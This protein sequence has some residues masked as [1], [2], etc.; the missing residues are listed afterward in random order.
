MQVICVTTGT[1]CIGGD[2]LTLTGQS[3]N[4]CHA[5][6]VARRCLI[7]YCYQQLQLLVDEDSTE[8]IFERSPDNDRFRLKPSITFHLYISTSPCGDGRLFAPQEAP[9]EPS[10][11]ATNPDQLS[12]Q[13]GY[14]S[15]V[16]INRRNTI[17][18]LL[19][20]HSLRKSRGLLRT[21]IEAGE[22]TIPV[23]AKTLYQSMQTWDGIMGGE[24]LLTMSC[25]DK[26][27]RWNFIG[28]QGKARIATRTF[29]SHSS[30]GALLSSL[31]EPI[32]YTSMII[33]S[34]YHS[35]H[36]RRALFGR[37]EQVEAR[38]ATFPCCVNVTTGRFQIISDIPL[39][40]GLRRPFIS[41]VSS[42]EMRT[43]SRA[44]NHALIWNCVDDKCEIIDTASGL[45][46]SR[47]SP[48][49]CCC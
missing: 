13:M 20:R 10:P 2:R 41:G 38:L 23:M 17:H 35:E 19:F 46:A 14:A 27:C 12:K 31:I 5:E 47:K 24:R 42:P 8:S 30:S 40:Y 33:G 25:S 4:D 21:K 16:V 3:L 37:I 45:T 36:I 44:P 29:S 48:V 28:L 7:R 26:L 18:L 34:L 39:P 49:D 9:V 43:T 1:K 11:S 22:G 15:V 32:F 6:I